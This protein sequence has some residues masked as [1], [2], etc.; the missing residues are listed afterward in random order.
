MRWLP[1]SGTEAAITDPAR[2]RRLEELQTCELIWPDDKYQR[3]VLTARSPGPSSKLDG[4]IFS[5]L[6]QN[7]NAVFRRIRSIS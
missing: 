6:V 7:N 5:D 3:P 2:R 1:S 4:L